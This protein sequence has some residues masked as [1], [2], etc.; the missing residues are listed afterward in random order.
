[1]LLL[2]FMA[3]VA[4][5]INYR[6]REIQKREVLRHQALRGQMNPHFIFNALNSINY[7]ISRNDRLSA[8]RYISDFSKLIRTTL[9]N[10]NEEFVKLSIELGSLEEYLKIEHLRFGDRFDYVI[11]IDPQITAETVNVS[12][13]LVQPFIE[14]A[15]WHG[16][17]GLDERKGMIR[18]IF[19]LKEKTIVCTVEDDGI[20]R[21][22]SEA[23][24]DVNNT[25]KS[26]GIELAM[27]RMRIINNIHLTGYQI[28]ITDL[29]P[30]RK[31][32]GTR[33]EIEIP[34]QKR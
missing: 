29:Y 11:S 12:P 1:V 15:I 32:T 4:V 33:V 19:S 9:S 8:N 13:G 21:K 24:K 16:I 23:M 26:R 17:M 2:L 5:F 20:G 3:I 6:N 10:M 22:R 7:F 18:V 14:N 31:D 28:R 30:E 27:E 25:K 34:V